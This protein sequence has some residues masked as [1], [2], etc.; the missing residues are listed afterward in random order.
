MLSK[1]RQSDGPDFIDSMLSVD[2][3]FYLPDVL[4]IKTDIA[5]MTHSLEA[6]MPFLDHPFL[7]F[8]ARIPSNLK[9]KDQ[10]DPKYILK[11]AVEPYLPREVIYREKMGFRVPIEKWFRGELK[12]LTYDVLLSSTATQRGLF[13]RQFVQSMLDRHQ[14]GE[15]WQYR[16]WNLLMLE[17]W[18]QMFV[19][20]SLSSPTSLVAQGYRDRIEG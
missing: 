9:L 7:E 11:K 18:F 4:M 20:H 1:F 19:D 3:N 14:A 2:L 13:Q 17:L 10:S 15:N 6:R 5:G 16:I 8:A 12:E